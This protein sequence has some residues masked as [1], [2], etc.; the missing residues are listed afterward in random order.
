MRHYVFFLLLIV[1]LSVRAQDGISFYPDALAFKGD[2]LTV[3][4]YSKCTKKE[5]CDLADIEYVYDENVRV[6]RT[7]DSLPVK[8]ISERERLVELLT[9]NPKDDKIIVYLNGFNKLEAEHYSFD[10][11]G[12]K[13]YTSAETS[14][15]GYKSVLSY[16]SSGRVIKKVTTDEHK[17]ITD[18]SNYSYSNNGKKIQIVTTNAVGRVKEKAVRTLDDH[19]NP[20][21]CEGENVAENKKYTTKFKYTYDSHGNYTSYTTVTNGQPAY[22]HYRDITYK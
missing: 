10:E 3:K 18:I 13:I 1:S 5:K 21:L 9:K 22:S 17:A 7:Y 11:Q 14:I 16:D 2:V 20:V 8:G 6:I 4:M 19:N 15:L 12:D